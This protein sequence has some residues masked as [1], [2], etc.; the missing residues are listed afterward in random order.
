MGRNGWLRVLSLV[1]AFVALVT[2]IIT[3]AARSEAK[4]EELRRTLEVKIEAMRTNDLYHL[5]EEMV[6]VRE[7]LTA[8]ETKVDILLDNNHKGD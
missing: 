7:R 5:R 8:V 3:M 2:L 6:G 4:T 1:G